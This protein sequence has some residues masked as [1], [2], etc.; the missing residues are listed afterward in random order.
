MEIP[1]IPSLRHMGGCTSCEAPAKTGDVDAPRDRPAVEPGG[2]PVDDPAACGIVDASA[3][4][5]PHKYTVNKTGVTLKK[6]RRRSL[7]EMATDMA[8]KLQEHNAGNPSGSIEEAP[9]SLDIAAMLADKRLPDVAPGQ[10][11]T[12][13]IPGVKKKLKG[14]K[15]NQD[16]GLV[17]TPLQCSERALLVGVFDGHGK[18]GHHVSKFAAHALFSALA[19]AND[20]A[21]S[22]AEEVFKR[23]FVEAHRKVTA[24]IPQECKKSGTT[25]T[26]ALIIGTRLFVAHVGDS[27]CA[28]FHR[29]EDDA[30]WTGTALTPEHHGDLPGEKE[31]VLNAGGSIQSN[32]ENGPL[33][34]VKLNE[35]GRPAGASLCVTRSIGDN[36]LKD[37][38]VIAEP[39][40][41]SMKLRKND[42]CLVIG[43]D[44]LWEILSLQEV[45]EIVAQHVGSAM[46]A[47]QSLAFRAREKYIP[48]VDLRG[49]RDDISALVVYLPFRSAVDVKKPVFFE[50]RRLTAKM[51]I[52]LD[53][54]EDSSDE[55]SDSA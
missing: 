32:H 44:G 39:D 25:A 53:I 18:D 37:V 41:L 40:F 49:T 24:V 21:S 28:L 35:K 5:T 8:N 14:P 20:A 47:A 36:A 7:M 29:S 50:S 11:G 51:S 55:S 22:N 13:S 31:R 23:E 19:L 9:N 30:P 15:T 52:P 3:H 2:H 6:E 48:Q 46:N 43:S 38:G 16:Y 54:A 33:R 10:V 26:V 27:S 1:W 4:F 34:V 42:C 12:C 45:A 17:A